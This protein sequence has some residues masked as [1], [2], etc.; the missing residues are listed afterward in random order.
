I[1]Y[2]WDYP[3]LQRRHEVDC[4]PAEK[5]R[6]AERPED[7]RH[8]KA[9]HLFDL[10]PAAVI[11]GL[12][13]AGK[14]TILRHFAWRA[15]EDNPHAIVVFVEGKHVHADLLQFAGYQTET[16]NWFRLLAALFLQPGVQP[17]KFSPDEQATMERLAET[18]HA[19][20]AEH[21]AIVLL[22]AL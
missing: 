15:L 12:P 1:Y 14:T 18:L 10:V 7:L 13:G 20:F 4:H 17:R 2:K 5:R 16:V 22:D 6:E 21:R 11:V 3:D 19:E 9:D 8:L